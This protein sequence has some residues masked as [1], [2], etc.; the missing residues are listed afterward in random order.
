[1]KEDIEKIVERLIDERCSEIYAMV[2]YL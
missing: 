1:M 2:T